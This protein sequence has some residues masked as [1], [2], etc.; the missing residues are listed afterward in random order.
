MS[1]RSVVGVAARRRNIECRTERGRR[2]CRSGR[3]GDCGAGGFGGVGDADGS[4]LSPTWS[5][6]GGRGVETAGAD[7]AHAAVATT[8]AV[9]LQVTPVF[10]PPVTVAVNCCVFP[11]TTLAV[12]GLTATAIG[13]DAPGETVTAALADLV[14]SA[15]LTTLTVTDVVA[16]HGR[17]G[18]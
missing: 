17:C 6:H 4:R 15:A 16:G 3:D 8:D 13:W 1:G 12:V 18:I 10:E 7:G 14:L 2:R 11:A 5:T 9:D